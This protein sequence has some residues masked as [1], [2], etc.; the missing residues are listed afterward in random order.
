ME[1]H[2]KTELVTSIDKPIFIQQ[3]TKKCVDWN[4]IIP[5][6]LAIIS[7][8]IVIYDRIKKSKINGK[9]LSFA[10]TPKAKF[11]SFD[12]SNNKTEYNGQQYFIKLS[13]QVTLKNL[14]FQNV[15]IEV[16]YKND[17]KKYVGEIFWLDSSEW[18]INDKSYVLKIPKNEFLYFNNTLHENTV[19]FQYLM[20]IVEVNKSEVFEEMFITFTDEKGKFKKLLP[21][22]ISELNYN[23]MLFDREIWIE[24]N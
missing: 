8:A 4:F 7:L 20:F 11:E 13:L 12:L 1:N 10:Y 2:S 6:T 23:T 5:T 9:I 17:K 21:I 3:I 14:F 19:S 22:K 24:I 16:K 15:E 18:K